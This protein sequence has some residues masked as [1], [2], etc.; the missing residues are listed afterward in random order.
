MSHIFRTKFFKRSAFTFLAVLLMTSLYGSSLASAANSSYFAT[1]DYS[2]QVASNQIK[3][4]DIDVSF[5][6]TRSE[7]HVC[8]F[9]IE[10]TG[11]GVGQSGTWL[12]SGQSPTP[13]NISDS[14]T[15]GPA[16]ADGKWHTEAISDLN[17]G[18]YR[19]DVVNSAGI[20]TT[21]SFW[22]D[23]AT[24][25]DAIANISSNASCPVGAAI[26]DHSVIQMASLQGKAFVEFTIAPGCYDVTLSLVSYMAPNA[27][28]SRET[29]SQQV[30]YGA[31]TGVFSS[32]SPTFG[33]FK[34]EVPVP[35]CYWQLNFVFGQPIA[36]L[37]PAASSNFYQDQGRLIA[38]SE[39]GFTVCN[40]S[41]VITPTVT[42]P[43]VIGVPST[44]G[45]APVSGWT[46]V[47]SMAVGSLGI[48]AV[49]ISMK[50]NRRMKG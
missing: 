5:D 28:F 38:G 41:S 12:I 30:L 24:P 13:S 16:D 31:T 39:G 36:N 46:F 11:F 19:L 18:F 6:D 45:S 21:K 27:N 9:S 17:N 44:G 40:A 14:G 3:L 1:S 35:S 8:R 34:I 7:P 50:A 25:K 2:A 22:V 10:A 23:C 47:L 37:G 4:H 20:V 15:W 42:V 29:A 43:P 49:G 48:A 33:K 32:D 26:A